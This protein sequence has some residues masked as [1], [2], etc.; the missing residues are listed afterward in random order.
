MKNQFAWASALALVIGVASQVETKAAYTNANGTIITNGTII[1]T[2]RAANDGH[3]FRQSSSTIDDM[4][5]NRGP[6]CTPGDVAMGEWLMDNG[7]SIKLLP[8]RALHAEAYTNAVC[9]NVFGNP[10]NP[11]LYY[12]G[13]PGPANS[14][15]AYNELLSAML[16]VISGSGSS[17]DVAP[18]NTN[19]VGIICGENT[20]LGA[21]DSGVPGSHAEH[22]FYTHRTSSNKTSP[23]TDGLYMR[24]L[25]ANHPILQ[26]IPLDA[27]SR[28][29]IWRDPYPQENA[30]VLSPGGLP[31]YQI[32]WTCA[33]IS[34]GASVPA[35]GLNIL[36]VLDSATNQVVFAVIDR[37]GVLADTTQ[38]PSSPWYRKTTAPAR[39]VHFFV[40]E[41][42]SG[43][44]RRCFNALSV[45][46]RLLF[47]RACQWAMGE[48][49]QAYSGVGI[50]EAAS[51]T[52]QRFTNSIGMSFVRIA[53]GTYTMGYWQ[54]AALPTEILNVDQWFPDHGDYEKP[55][56]SVTITR[57]FYLGA[58]EVSNAEYERFDPSHHALRGKLGFSTN[59]NEAVVFVS[60]LEAKAFCDWLSFR[61]GQPYR[62]PTEAE[63][64]FAC[65]AG[66]TTHFWTGD[67]LPAQYQK[68]PGN[69]WYPDPDRSG[70]TNIVPL[71]VGQTL[72][73]PWGLY[74][75]HGN[76]EEWCYDWYGPYAAGAQ[77]DPV[78]RADALAKVTRGGSHSTFAYHLRSE[79]RMGALPEDKSWYIG[80]R[81]ALGDMPAT[82]PLP[83]VPPEP[84]QTNVS[85]TIPPDITNGP[86]PQTPF[87]SGPIRYV[88]VPINVMGP[89]YTNHNHDPSIIQCPNGDLL[90][91]W[92]TTVSEGGRELAMA[93][94]RLRYGLTN[95]ETA[96]SF[97]D[98][99]DRNDHAPAFYA[100]T[101]GT[102][103]HFNGVSAGATWGPLA[104]L[105]RFSTN[106]GADWS[107]P[108]LILP[109]HDVRHQMVPSVFRT[110]GG[111]VVLTADAVSTGNGG[112][113][114]HISRDGMLTWND[115]GAGR[116]TPTFTDGGTGAWLAG[117]H[118]HIVELTDGRW[119]A[120]GRGDSINGMMPKSISSD[121]GTNWTYSAS[122]FQP[123]GGGQRVKLLR[124]KEGPLFLASF[125]SNMLIT[126]ASGGTRAVSGL[127]GAL[128][129][130][131][132]VTWP[133]QRL[134]SDDRT[135]RS[136]EALDGELFTL[137]FSN[138][139]PNGYLD[140]VQARNG[141][142][143][144]ISSRQHYQFNLKW[145]ATRPPSSPVS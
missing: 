14:G 21:S 116:P 84:Y 10:N 95:W 106:N 143:H 87:F 105:S 103:Y 70:P 22:F 111:A 18:P 54:S 137:S 133:F 90:A 135:G 9:L 60:W 31:N 134:I 119:M 57:P 69:C 74:D 59:D 36:G 114:V 6:G 32:S 83:A 91:I 77:S 101:N 64:E 53:S 48:P 92:Y 72:P 78:G 132:G 67:T 145:L 107:K 66:T 144:L 82:A 12:D 117:I 130:D 118:G 86:D 136:V 8:D 89:L 55:A 85:Q 58:Y 123:I 23:T 125:C 16:V 11:Q 7:Y 19:G 94:S 38:D 110:S 27:S 61:E 40:N 52:A 79:N 109:E 26:G 30:H 46:G 115:P 97:Y 50:V 37:G 126:D 35:P 43:N 15:L 138:A 45:W 121:Q 80:F 142:I 68:N 2:T 75:M 3:F 29:Q 122:I 131:D 42:G 100:D 34:S 39:M 28:V 108:L 98:L 127:F 33:D 4:D 5:D 71:T 56:H 44:S 88:N 20:V 49:L 104:V 73:N 1:I 140:A 129:Y 63:W 120:L 47:L 139:E 13:H 17:A 81:V 96:S 112:T 51:P 76:V 102:I 41:Q 65:R 62:L 99:P 93:A 24:V 25:K 141:V 113:A 128:S 124:L